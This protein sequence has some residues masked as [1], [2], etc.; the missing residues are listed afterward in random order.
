MLMIS[1]KE[2]LCFCL[3]LIPSSNISLQKEACTSTRLNALQHGLVGKGKSIFHCY[4][5]KMH[6]WQF[7]LHFALLPDPFWNGLFCF[8]L[9]RL[10]SLTPPRTNKRVFHK[11]I[12]LSWGMRWIRMDWV[13]LIWWLL[14]CKNECYWQWL[15]ICFW[16]LDEMNGFGGWIAGYFWSILRAEVKRGVKR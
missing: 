4:W 1:R 14:K 9:F 3:S 6:F 15:S 13:R 12:D 11:W 8:S 5:F 16:W 7:R 10:L 2:H